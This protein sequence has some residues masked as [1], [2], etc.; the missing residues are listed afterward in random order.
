[1]N[2]FYYDGF[3]MYTLFKYPHHTQNFTLGGI[4]L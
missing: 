2:Y 1:M 3:F 4:N